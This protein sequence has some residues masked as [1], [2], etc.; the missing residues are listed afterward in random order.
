MVNLEPRHLDRKIL[1]FLDQ[2]LCLIKSSQYLDKMKDG[3]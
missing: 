1:K 2:N 3:R